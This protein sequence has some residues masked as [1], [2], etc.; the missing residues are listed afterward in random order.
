M[1]HTNASVSILSLTWLVSTIVGC[2]LNQQHKSLADC[3]KTELQGRQRATIDLKNA[4]GF[5]W[6]TLYVSVGVGLSCD[7]IRKLIPA[8]I[9]DCSGGSGC[10]YFLSGKKI[11]LEEIYH[12]FW[13]EPDEDIVLINTN[14]Q[15]FLKVIPNNS[16]FLVYSE[17]IGARVIYNLELVLIDNSD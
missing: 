6:D 15:Y 5:K 8:R 16:K 3:I 9:T 12:P 14:G 4:M 17:K 13:D 1:K 2:S 11:E 7:S 10:Y